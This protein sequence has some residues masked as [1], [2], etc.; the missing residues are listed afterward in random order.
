MTRNQLR[1]AR[2]TY[3]LVAVANYCAAAA[4]VAHG[5]RVMW[6]DVD[7]T[8]TWPVAAFVVSLSNVWIANRFMGHVDEVNR[9]LDRLK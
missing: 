1:R 8:G 9:A 6:V 4:G 2:R 3:L 7:P 5:C